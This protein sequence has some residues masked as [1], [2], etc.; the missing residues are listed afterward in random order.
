MKKSVKSQF[1]KD[2]WESGINICKSMNI[3]PTV[4]NVHAAI[5][6]YLL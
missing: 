4:R 1:S 5:K 2:V 3:K 6:S